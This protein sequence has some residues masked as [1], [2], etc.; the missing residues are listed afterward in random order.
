MYVCVPDRAISHLP[1]ELKAHH[2]SEATAAR[3]DDNI[4]SATFVAPHG[5]VRRMGGKG[6]DALFSTFDYKAEQYDRAAQL[7]SGLRKQD[8]Q[9]RL[10]VNPLPFL[11]STPRPQLI[12]GL[13]GNIPVNP[14]GADPF[15]GVESAAS[16]QAFLEHQGLLHGPFVPSTGHKSVGEER[17]IR[18]KL[19]D[20]IQRLLRAIDDDWSDAQFQI[21]VDEDELVLVQ[22]QESSVDNIKGLQSYMNMF[23]K[24]NRTCHTC[25]ALHTHMCTLRSCTCST[26]TRATAL[27]L[28]PCVHVCCVC[29]RGSPAI[30]SEFCL[31]KLPELWHHS[32]DGALYYA[33]RPPWVKRRAEAS[34]L[35]INPAFGNAK[36]QQ[37]QQKEQHAA[38][39]HEQLMLTAGTGALTPAT[40]YATAAARS[41]A[42][43]ADDAQ[44]SNAGGMAPFDAGAQSGGPRAAPAGGGGAPLWQQQNA[45][46]TARR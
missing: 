15:E 21:Y 18:L 12:N 11:Y 9:R 31:A 32:S 34:M 7:Q 13:A 16:R 45:A 30:V 26:C 41:G 8:E 24:T 20:M 5:S 29:V 2:V 17:I 19:P 6:Q 44:R 35:A 25:S 37:Q 43:A 46:T 28:P 23:V 3:I 36:Q 4:T 22:F 33:L 38:V 14:A 10:Q 40:P 42:S 27:T 1:N 39:Q